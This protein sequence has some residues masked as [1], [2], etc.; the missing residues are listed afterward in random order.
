MQLTLKDDQDFGEYDCIATNGLSPSDDRK[1][2][3]AHVMNIRRRF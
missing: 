3:I 2:E 1:M